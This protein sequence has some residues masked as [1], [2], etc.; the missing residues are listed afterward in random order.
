MKRGQQV[1]RTYDIEEGSG[2]IL[3]FNN[4]TLSQGQTQ[5]FVEVEEYMS[6]WLYN[7]ITLR[8]LENCLRPREIS[9]TGRKLRL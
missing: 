6:P 1:L 7:T 2:R 5:W 3:S 4:I 8:V 9:D